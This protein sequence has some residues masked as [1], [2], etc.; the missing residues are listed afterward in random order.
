MPPARGFFR[1]TPRD[2]IPA[3]CVVGLV[4]LSFWTFLC[5]QSLSFPVLA[6]A[7]LAIALGMCWNLQCLSHNFIHNPFF[8]WPWLNRAFSILE[9]LA[10]GL[11]HVCYNHYHLNHHSGDN[12]RKGPDGTTRDWSS[13]YRHSKD[14]EPEPFWSYVLLGYWR[15]ELGPLLRVIW[16]HGWKE[17]TQFLVELAVLACFWGAMAWFDPWYFV[18]FY[19]PSYYLGWML[20]YAQGYTEHYYTEPA[21][22]RAN[23]V[24]SYNRLYNLLW[25]NNGYHQ[26]HHWDP[27]RHWTRMPELHKEIEDELVRNGTRV[28]KGP[29]LTALVEYWWK[30]ELKKASGSASQSPGKPVHPPLSPIG[31]NAEQKSHS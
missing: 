28:I 17:V 3:V 19:L 16:R 25:F 7:F 9:T 12:D 10:I 18:C 20:S 4:A 24:N 27:K 5:Y 23:S 13:I 8:G 26:E 2:A 29:H 6:A 21:N 31:R 22:P 15:V 1:Y 30:G 14:E 11:P